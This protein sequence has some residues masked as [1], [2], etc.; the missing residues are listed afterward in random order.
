MKTIMLFG[1][2]DILHPGHI[3]LF[4]QAKKHADILTV[5]IAQDVNVKKNKKH[6]TIFNQ[7]ERIKMLKNIILIDKVIL[8]NKKDYYQVILKNKPDIIA[9]GY[10]Q[11]DCGPGLEEFLKKNNLKAKIIRLKAY[12]PQILKSHK[13]RNYIES[14]I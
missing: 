9:L 2:F 7:R 1:T 8:G 4:E 14:M 10:D 3:N 12:Q 6:Q 5:V 11:K 13:V